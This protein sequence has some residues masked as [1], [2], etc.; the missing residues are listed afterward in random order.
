MYFQ[1]LYHYYTATGD[2]ATAPPVEDETP[3]SACST[4]HVIRQ[5]VQLPT[6]YFPNPRN[7]FTYRLIIVSG[8]S[9]LFTFFLS[10]L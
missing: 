9:F 5:S 4:T 3:F 10:F 7:S 8:Y 1:Y 2:V 6:I